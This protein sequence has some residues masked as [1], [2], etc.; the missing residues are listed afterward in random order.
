MGPVLSAISGSA[1]V[2]RRCDVNSEAAKLV[3]NCSG[4]IKCGVA[5]L[6]RGNDLAPEPSRQSKQ[7]LFAELV[8]LFA[9]MGTNHGSYRTITSDVTKL[10]KR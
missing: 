9:N 3:C 7:I 8:G 2:G 10:T 6:G 1:V 5:R 4:Q